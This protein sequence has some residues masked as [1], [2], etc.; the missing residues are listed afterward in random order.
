MRKIPGY[1]GFV[2]VSTGISPTD[3]F[4][5]RKGAKGEAVFV[6]DTPYHGDFR[7]DLGF[8]FVG[9]ATRSYRC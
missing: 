6:T 7:I 3:Y 2:T 9:G 8:A 5:Y 1:D 4:L